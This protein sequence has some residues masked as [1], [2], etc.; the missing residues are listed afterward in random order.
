MLMEGQVK[1]HNPQNISGASRQNGAAA[2]ITTLNNFSSWRLVLNRTDRKRQQK[3]VS[4]SSSG[5]IHNSRSP[6]IQNLLNEMLFTLFTSCLFYSGCSFL[7]K[8]FGRMLLTLFCFRNIKWTSQLHLTFHQCKGELILFLR[9]LWKTHWRKQKKT[10]MIF[11][12]RC[13]LFL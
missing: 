4:Y 8:L 7:H 13:F 10:M 2:S 12:R 3:Q 9:S 11:I 1:F 6:E 5:T